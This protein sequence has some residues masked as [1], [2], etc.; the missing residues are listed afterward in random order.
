MGKEDILVEF[1][2]LYGEKLCTTVKV[3]KQLNVTFQNYTDEKDWVDNAF[4]RAKEA[5]FEMYEN[6]L[7]YRCFPKERG[8]CQELLEAMGLK[9]YSPLDIVRQT[10]GVMVDDM[11]WIRF[12]DER[13]L[14]WRDVAP[15]WRNVK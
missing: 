9:E 8:N 13:H 2:Y 5:D 4:G 7:K 12:A 14:Q 10:H 3:D 15:K 6:L 1:D 11:Y